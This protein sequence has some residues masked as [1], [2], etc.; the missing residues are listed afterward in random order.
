MD[1]FNRSHPNVD[2]QKIHHKSNYIIDE[3][4]QEQQPE[5]LIR[6]FHNENNS[7]VLCLPHIF[8]AGQ[9]VHPA[10]DYA[11]SLMSGD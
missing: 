4:P 7:F 10:L 3:V 5:C 2:L 11:I 8:Q 6:Q 1:R 9:P